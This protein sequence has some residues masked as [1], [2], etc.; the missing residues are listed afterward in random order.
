VESYSRKM[1]EVETAIYTKLKLNRKN[2]SGGSG[3]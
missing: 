3:R 2:W 1:E